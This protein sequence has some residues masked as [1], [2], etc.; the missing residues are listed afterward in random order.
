[1]FQAKRAVQQSVARLSSSVTLACVIWSVVALAGTAQ[2]QD[3]SSFRGRLSAVPIDFVTVLTTKGIGSFTAVL[4]GNTLTIAGTFE[5][6][7][8]RA[9][10]AHVHRGFKGLH[11]PSVFTLTVTNDTNGR[12]SGSL[13]LTD[14]DVQDLRSG[15]FY[16]Q[17]HSEVNPDG[18][19]RGWILDSDQQ[20]DL[21]D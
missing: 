16:L 17:I 9:T 18:H 21:N 12:I 14:A 3:R 1:M 11:G 5:G 15:R 6:M 4:E 7:N 10:V 13:T 8:A 20:G 2:A 19:L